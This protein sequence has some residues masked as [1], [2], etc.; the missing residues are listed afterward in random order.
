[1]F[2]LLLIRF[3]KSESVGLLFTES[4]DHVRLEMDS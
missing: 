1:M 3:V 4:V 2:D